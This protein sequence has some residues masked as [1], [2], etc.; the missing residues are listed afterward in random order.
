[1]PALPVNTP[2]QVLFASLVGTTIEFF[3]FYIY[4]TAAALVFPALLFPSS[5][6]ATGTL[7]S[8][9]TFGIAF[10]ARPISSASSGNARNPRPGSRPFLTGPRMA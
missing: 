10:L 9:A 4:G 5:D 7:A 6:P 1:M 2:R 8:L 3:D